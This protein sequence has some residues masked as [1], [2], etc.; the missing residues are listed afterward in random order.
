M[1][2]QCWIHFSMVAFVTM[3]L[4]QNTNHIANAWMVPTTTTQQQPQKLSSSNSFLLKS[5]LFVPV[6][7]QFTMIRI[8]SPQHYHRPSPHLLHMAGFGDAAA[9]SE[10][11]EVKLKPKQQ[12]D[13]YTA[14]KKEPSVVVGVKVVTPTSTTTTTTATEN[15]NENDHWLV[16]GAVK[17][18]ATIPTDV[19]VARQ[20]ALLVE[21][22][23]WTVSFVCFITNNDFHL[24]I[25]WG[26]LILSITFTNKHSMRSAYI[27]CKYLPRHRLNGDTSSMTKHRS[28]RIVMRL[29]W[30]ISNGLRSIRRYWIPSR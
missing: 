24:T 8:P 11:K 7:Q 26:H 5:R 14:L 15:N 13:R 30:G 19:A 20:R 27:H 4:L 28:K 3:L 21:V 22:C 18:D 9:S 6:T 10:S 16:V 17:S 25:W 1:P 29:R 2:E 12:W 23:D